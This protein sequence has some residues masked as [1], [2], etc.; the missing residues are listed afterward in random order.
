MERLVP[1]EH[2]TGNHYKAWAG[3]NS[4]GNVRKLSF[5]GCRWGEA[6]WGKTSPKILTV[7]KLWGDIRRKWLLK[8]QIFS[9]NVNLWH[10]K[11]KQMCWRQE[12]WEGPWKSPWLLLETLEG[13]RQE[14]KG[15][16]N[17]NHHTRTSCSH[18]FNKEQ[19]K[20]TACRKSPFSIFIQFIISGKISRHEKK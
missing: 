12:C 5:L 7:F 6:F 4:L 17:T 16:A 9:R 8:G 20:T 18:L 15:N 11:E 10:I 2:S 14:E 1:Q 3:E 19:K 13:C